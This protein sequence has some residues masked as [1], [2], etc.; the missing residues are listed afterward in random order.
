MV[1]T[2]RQRFLVVASFFLISFACFSVFSSENNPKEHRH[3]SYLRAE[4]NA[5]DTSELE[6]ILSENHSKSKEINSK[7]YL[8]EWRNQLKGP[9]LGELESQEG[10][11]YFYAMEKEFGN[12]AFFTIVFFDGKWESDDLYAIRVRD[13]EFNPEKHELTHNG[14]IALISSKNLNNSTYKGS[15]KFSFWTKKGSIDENG[16]ELR[17]QGWVSIPERNLY[18]QLELHILTETEYKEPIVTYCFIISCISVAL[19]FAFAK[20]TQDCALSENHAKKTSM[21]MLSMN[22]IIDCFLCLWHLNRAFQ[23]FIAFDYLMLASFWNFAAFMVVQGRLLLIVWKAHNS[24]IQNQGLE[25]LR[26]HYSNF[27]SRFCLL[28]IGV[29]IGLVVF[30]FLY[31]LTI[32]VLHSFFVPQI[33]MNA[34]NGY[35]D[36]VSPIFI[37]TLF[38]ARTTLILYFFGCPSNFIVMEPNYQYCLVFVCYMGLQVAFM[39][40]QRSRL[41]PRFFVPRV[42]RPQAYNYY[43]SFAEEKD[44]EESECIICMTPLNI[45]GKNSPEVVNKSRTMHTPCGHMF[46]EDCLVNWMNIKMECP[47]CRSG[48]PL[49]EE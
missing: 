24:E 1:D 41:G 44:F 4:K 22:A 28:V 36:S 42:L 21:L 20:H 14:T 45:P 18:I 34:K 37:L 39:L 6:S 26:R 23:V 33:Y 8:G 49:L 38:G 3:T 30:D 40:L 25:A 43:R 2:V 46:H 13:A 32:L 29:V 10:R 48:L 17:S 5:S 19:I 15:S 16:T 11:A 47:T 35:R 27:Q 31:L 9:V 12:S 7:M